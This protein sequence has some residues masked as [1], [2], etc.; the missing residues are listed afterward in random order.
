MVHDKRT[1]SFLGV[2]PIPK[3]WDFI[4]YNWYE[5]AIYFIHRREKYTSSPCMQVYRLSVLPQSKK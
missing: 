1:G 5:G 3:H 2:I 4:G